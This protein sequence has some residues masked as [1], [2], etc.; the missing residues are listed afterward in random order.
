MMPVKPRIHRRVVRLIN[1]P[2]TS[3]FDEEDAAFVEQLGLGANHQTQF[4]M[5]RQWSPEETKETYLVNSLS[6]VL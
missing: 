2:S 1:I 6:S 4:T 3:S 5:P